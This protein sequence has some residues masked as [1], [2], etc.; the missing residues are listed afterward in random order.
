MSVLSVASIIAC[1]IDTER[2]R[3]SDEGVAFSIVF[4]ESKNE[5]KW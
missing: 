5:E 4:F 2:G 1:P 3:V